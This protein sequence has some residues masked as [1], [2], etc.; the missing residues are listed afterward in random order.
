MY[1]TGNY[2]QTISNMQALAFV[3]DNLS[4][5]PTWIQRLTPGQMEQLAAVLNRWRASKEAVEA[6]QPLEEVERR[7]VMR[8]LALCNGDVCAAA[9]QL[10]IGKTTLYRRLKNWGFKASNW[11]AIHQAV[12]LA[13]VCS[14][15]SCV[16]STA[17]AGRTG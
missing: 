13:A 8:A 16:S 10:R 4:G 17:A 5:L 14:R 12:A 15:R 9:R 7:E 3:Y 2:R 6:V 1:E 11:R